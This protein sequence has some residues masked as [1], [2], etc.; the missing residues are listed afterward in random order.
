[1]EHHGDNYENDY[2]TDLI[3]RKAKRFV[4]NYDEKNPFLMVLAT[5][6]PHAPFTPAPQHSAGM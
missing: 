2:L 1:M 6:A 4:S 5:P 3:G